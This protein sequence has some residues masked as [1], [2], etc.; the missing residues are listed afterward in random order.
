MDMLDGETE[1]RDYALERVIMLSDGVF[2]IA[3]TLLA[4]DLRPPEHWDRTMAGLFDTM[5]GP[6]MSFF[7]SFFATAMFWLAHRRMFGVYR[8]ADGF[9]SVLNLILLGEIVLIPVATRVLSEM[10]ASDDALR[11][12]LGLFLLIGLTNATSWSYVAFFTGMLRPPRRGPFS[13]L[14]VAVIYAFVPVGMTSLG[15]LAN[16]P[17]KHFLPLL[18]PVVILCVTGL[19]RLATRL[20]ERGTLRPLPSPA[21]AGQLDG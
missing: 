21:A 13:K 14:A 3:M 2:G 10:N 19:R 1:I 8:R 15:V 18:I 12:Y 20:D 9:I 5:A 16:R 4:L 11:L 17:G 7:W 6:F